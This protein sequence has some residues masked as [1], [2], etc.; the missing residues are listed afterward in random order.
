M[1]DDQDTTLKQIWMLKEGAPKSLWNVKI[2]PAFLNFVS[3]SNKL[4]TRGRSNSSVAAYSYQ[5]SNN[6]IL[7]EKAKFKI[8]SLSV[9]NMV[10]Q[11]D[12]DYYTYYSLKRIEKKIDKTLLFNALTSKRKW[13]IGNDTIRFTNVNDDIQFGHEHAFYKLSVD[14]DGRKF[15]GTYYI[16]EFE[17]HVFLCFL[18]DGEYQ[19][20]IYEIMS[21][22]D[23]TI[24][25]KTI[26]GDYIIDVGIM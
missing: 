12:S 2:V 25:Y 10:L 14:K 22:T 23:K 18:I 3:I 26:G 5:I 24:R 19:E 15:F 16:D 20:K 4:I 6:E 11:I 21:A 13:I 7:T 17:G 9:N 1:I 8:I